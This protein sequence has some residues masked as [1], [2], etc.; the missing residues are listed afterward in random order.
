MIQKFTERISIACQ[1]MQHEN[2]EF[3]FRAFVDCVLDTN[4]STYF[5]KCIQLVEERDKNKWTDKVFFEQI[6]QFIKELSIPLVQE[7]EKPL[8]EVEAIG[9]SYNGGKFQLKPLS[10]S[11]NSGE[12]IGLVGEN[13][14]GKTTLLRLLAQEI[15]S[16][17]G[18]V[19]YDIP[20]SKNA[21]DLRTQLAFVPQR[22]PTWRGSL[23]DNL[24]FTAANY[25]RKGEENQQMVD[26]MILRFGLWEYRHLNWAELSSGYKMRFELARTFLRRPKIVLLDEPLGNLDIKSQQTIL[27]DLKGLA[28]SPTNPIGIILSSQQLYEVEKVA[29]KVLFLKKG[30]LLHYKNK[31]EKEETNTTI[32]ELDA[33][34]S[35][36]E[37]QQLFHSFQEVKIAFT[38]GVYVIQ[39]PKEHAFKQALQLLASSSLEINYI[40]DI[41]LSTRRFFI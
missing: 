33:T 35:M 37:L 6:Q 22:T 19:R 23:Y 11:V 38:G 28:Q 1:A 14:N 40:R 27:E 7:K 10:L 26:M 9:R 21:Y 18:T 34:T 20:F 8:L 24:K 16:D 31:V 13:G 2:Y 5:Q 15:E 29:D 3:G 32:M 41:S 39:L 25:G 36:S 4:N 30:E 17:M 12:I